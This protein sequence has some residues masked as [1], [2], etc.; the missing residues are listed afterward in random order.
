M[1][2]GEA[3]CPP[4]VRSQSFSEPKLLN[5][6]LHKGLSGFFFS[7]LVGARW[8]KS[9]EVFNLEFNQVLTSGVFNP[10]CVH[11]EPL[12]IHHLQFRISYPGTGSCGSLHSAPV[13]TDSPCSPASLQSWG[14]GVLCVLPL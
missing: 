7:P 11:P 9:A 13:S 3:F 6:E 12:A 8:L 10:H 4:M 2:R 14:R 5:C 1:G